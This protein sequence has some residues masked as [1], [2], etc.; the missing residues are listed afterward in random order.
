MGTMHQRTSVPRIQLRAWSSLMS[1]DIYYV[2]VLSCTIVHYFAL[3]CIILHW[4]VRFCIFCF[5]CF[6]ALESDL[7]TCND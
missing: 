5:T 4:N 1:S 6:E 2:P 3:F 7:M